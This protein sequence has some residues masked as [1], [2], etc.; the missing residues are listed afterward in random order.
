MYGQNLWIENCLFNKSQRLWFAMFLSMVQYD[1]GN[2][3]QR[4]FKAK[5]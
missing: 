5:I 3:L 1:S 4:Y 2:L